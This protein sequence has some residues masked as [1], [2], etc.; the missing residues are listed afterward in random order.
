METE[1]I[2]WTS[3][4]NTTTQMILLVSDAVRHIIH[5]YN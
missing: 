3:Q 2:L 1:I 4:E 5:S